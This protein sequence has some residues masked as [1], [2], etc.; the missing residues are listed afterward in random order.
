MSLAP[1]SLSTRVTSSRPANALRQAS[2]STSAPLRPMSPPTKRKRVPSPA[3]GNER[4]GP[5]GRKS[6]RS[7]PLG[8]VTTRSASTP[9]ST[10]IA[11]T[12]SLGTHSSSTLESSGASQSRGIAPNSQ[13]WM[14][15]SRPA[16]AGL[17]SG[18]H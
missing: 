13:G 7:T 14:I 4:S 17:R 11:R 16:R 2:K 5:S 12:Y 8:I 6:S 18:G 9:A 10:Y 1:K 15:A 3:S